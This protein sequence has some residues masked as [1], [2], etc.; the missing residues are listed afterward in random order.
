M[1]ADPAV[2]ASFAQ[3]LPL[4]EDL[5]LQVRKQA[6]FRLR[7]MGLLTLLLLVLAIAGVFGAIW[8]LAENVTDHPLAVGATGF[9][10]AIAAVALIAMVRDI[11]SRWF[12]DGTA[13]FVA[14]FRDQVTIPVLRASIPAVQFRPGEDLP[15]ETIRN[16]GLYLETFKYL[17]TCGLF[18]GQIEGAPFAGSLVAISSKRW[19][20]RDGQREVVHTHFQGA[21]FHL[22]RPLPVAGTVRIVD[23][24]S[25]SGRRSGYIIRRHGRIVQARNLLEHID[26]EAAI[27]LDEGQTAPPPLPESVFATWLE[28]RKLLGEPFHLSFNS[29]GFY[30]GVPTKIHRA[31]ILEDAETR[32]R[33]PAELAEDVEALR[34]GL[35]ALEPLRRIFP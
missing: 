30:L 7:T 19:S 2:I 24:P 10:L 27:L 18:T 15:A 34:Q 17:K 21:F 31:G 29:R 14:A 28:L 11:A 6:R 13:P 1:P 16:S 3:R 35:K 9:L 12:A 20:G 25:Y 22:A 23:L 4:V 26:P 32:P 5:R 33:E 8:Y